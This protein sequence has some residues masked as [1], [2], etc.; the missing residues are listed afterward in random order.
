MIYF[1]TT[2]LLVLCMWYCFST[3]FLLLFNYCCT[4][5]ALLLLYYCCTC[6]SS[7]VSCALFCRGLALLADDP[8][9]AE[10][11]TFAFSFL[12]TIGEPVNNRGLVHWSGGLVYWWARLKL[13]YAQRVSHVKCRPYV[14]R[15]SIKAAFDMWNEWNELYI[16]RSP[17]KS[18]AAYR[19]RCFRS[20]D[21]IKA[22]LDMWN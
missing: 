14:L 16:K 8:G 22:A 3:A 11:V 10:R 15:D 20:R 21:S 4:C 1:C 2:A 9:A 17:T 5:I 6:D 7:S 19:F 18:S 13:V 12:L